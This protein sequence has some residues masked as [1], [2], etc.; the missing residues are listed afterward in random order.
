MNF[1]LE[2]TKKI[3]ILSFLSAF[4]VKKKE[5]IFQVLIFFFHN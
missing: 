4:I 3:K 1:S 2:T 5:Q